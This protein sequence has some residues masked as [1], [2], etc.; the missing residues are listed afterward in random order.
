MVSGLFSAIVMLFVIV[1][2]GAGFGSYFWFW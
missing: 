2:G 1:F